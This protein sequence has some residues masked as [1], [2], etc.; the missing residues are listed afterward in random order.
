MISKIFVSGGSHCIGGGFNWENVV[1][2][3]RTEMNI[4]IENGFD[5]TYPKLLGNYFNSDVIFEGEFGGSINRMIRKTYEYIFNNN[6][7]DTLF[8]LEVPPGWRDEFYSNELNRNVN[9]T[10]G[11]ILSPDD[12]TDVA[13]GNDV[14]DLHKIHKDITNYFY[15]FIDYEIDKRKWM[16]SL[17][18]LLSYFQLHKLKYIVMD[19]GDLQQF[20]KSQNKS[21]DDY[22]LLWFDKGNS[23]NNW[24]NEN[25]LTIK[26]ETNNKSND[27]HLSIKGH[28]MVAEKIINYVKENKS[29]FS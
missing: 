5:I 26:L 11:N 9:M 24:I 15:N 19:N 25:G 1:D 2:V 16:Y 7:A 23:L 10:I 29:S 18:G 27:E 4:N 6:V 13:N 20:L 12:N 14:K 3:Y 21:E 22:N 8:I 17:I 28:Q